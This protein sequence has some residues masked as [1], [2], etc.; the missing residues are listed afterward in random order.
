[1]SYEVVSNSPKRAMQLPSLGPTWYNLHKRSGKHVDIPVDIKAFTAERK[2]LCTYEHIPF[3]ESKSRACSVASWHG[4][5]GYD[6]KQ[7]VMSPWARSCLSVRHLSLKRKYSE[8]N[9]YVV[10]TTAELL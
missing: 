9:L 10:G 1:M 6:R 2:L 8:A 4:P 7:N 5:M 3:G